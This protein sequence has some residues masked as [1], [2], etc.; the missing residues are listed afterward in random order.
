MFESKVL[1]NAKQRMSKE[2]IGSWIFCFLLFCTFVSP[3]PE[4][5]Q[6]K[7]GPIISNATEMGFIVST[8]FCLLF[9]VK[10]K[11]QTPMVVKI[12]STVFVAALFAAGLSKMIFQGE[13]VIGF[14]KDLRYIIPLLCAVVVA[15]LGPVFEP[16]LV[17]CGIL[18]GVAAS[19]IL[20]G[21]FLVFD[22][23]FI[24]EDEKLGAIE[25]QGL[26]QGRLNNS[27]SGFVFFGLPILFC[28]ERNN[29][30]FQLRRLL[31]FTSILTLIG[32][33]ATFS[34]TVIL[35]ILIFVPFLM[36]RNWSWREFQKG[37]IVLT[38]ALA[39]AAILYQ[40]VP[41]AQRQV[42]H[43][44]LVVTGGIDKLLERGYYG[45]REVLYEGY[46]ELAMKYPLFGCNNL[47]PKSI[48]DR[49]SKTGLRDVFV[50]DISFFTILLS[51]GAVV[52]CAYLFFLASIYIAARSMEKKII[53]IHKMP[54]PLLR[55]IIISFPLVAIVSLNYD[56]LAR[57][58]PI[59]FIAILFSYHKLQPLAFAQNERN[60]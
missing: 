44:I 11:W 32:G 57:N 18:T 42:D 47:T 9:P 2:K 1:P 46:L 13:T 30:N 36:L 3:M 7:F 19:F 29:K 21:Y 40:T 48:Y 59:F 17:W 45:T 4:I 8:L 22:V 26:S 20:S 43:R 51:Y 34:R 6:F 56:A 27:N 33:I 55:V 14:I 12:A 25:I 16:R 39:F 49:Y 10:G 24:I 28:L 31:V 5:T 60:I 41:E 15:R 53:R 37:S 50:T 23:S 52:L 38:C 54:S 35:Y 58:V